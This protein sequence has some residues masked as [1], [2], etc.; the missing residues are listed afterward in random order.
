MYL[1][2][3]YIYF[4]DEDVEVLGYEMKG[5]IIVIDGVEYWLKGATGE[6]FYVVEK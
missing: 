1:T 5:N 6:G 4:S 3:D 2:D